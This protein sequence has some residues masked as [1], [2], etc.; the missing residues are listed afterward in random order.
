MPNFID[1]TAK[2]FNRLLVLERAPNTKR[3]TRWL[4]L[5]DCGNRTVVAMGHLVRNHTKSCG[6][7]R[8]ENTV[9]RSIKH[10]HKL[11]RHLTREYE[12][13]RGAKARCFRS[14]HGRFSEWGGRGISMCKEWADSFEKFFQYIGPCPPGKSLDRYP[15]NNGNY[16][17]GNVRWATP[18]EQSSNQRPR[19]KHKRGKYRNSKI[20]AS[21]SL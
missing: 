7:W 21:R 16:E 17:P 18:S 9:K 2:R 5:C 6:C 11:R 14:T 13:W 3:T 10:G 12:S 8:I 4:C 19:K 1:L 15:N 20:S